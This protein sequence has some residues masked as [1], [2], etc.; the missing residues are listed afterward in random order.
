M[1]PYNC[2][3]KAVAEEKRRRNLHLSNWITSKEVGKIENENDANFL[4]LLRAALKLR[5]LPLSRLNAKSG[6]Y[7]RRSMLLTPFLVDIN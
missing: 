5:F 4:L 1:L 6:N 2:E 3:A 7:Y